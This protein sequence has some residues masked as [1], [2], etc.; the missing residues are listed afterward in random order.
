MRCYD[1]L[2]RRPLN[3]PWP[4]VS[5]RWSLQQA[6]ALER[7][8]IESNASPFITVFDNRNYQDIRVVDGREPGR[9]VFRRNLQPF[10]N[11]G[12]YCV[13]CQPVDDYDVEHE[14]YFETLP[15]A[16]EVYLWEMGRPARGEPVSFENFQISYTSGGGTTELPLPEIGSVVS[17]P[18]AF[19]YTIYR[20][21]DGVYRRYSVHERLQELA[22]FVER[23]RIIRGLIVYDHL[24]LQFLPFKMS[25]LT[26]AQLHALVTGTAA[27]EAASPISPTLQTRR[28]QSAPTPPPPPTPP[29]APPR[30]LL[31][32]LTSSGS[33]EF[34]YELAGPLHLAIAT[35][36]EGTRY[37][38]LDRVLKTRLVMA[39]YETEEAVQVVRHRRLLLS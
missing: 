11:T 38:I 15:E 33:A 35:L 18:Q 7:P 30:F 26:A 21:T 17:A 22:Q 13:T 2:L 12:Q 24:L 14:L 5:L 16:H 4:I 39:P 31:R 9:V 27:E 32:V 23:M 20:L 34:T 1:R 25:E 28:W 10:T 37:E 19:R 6:Q 8:W 3:D 36:T 29:P